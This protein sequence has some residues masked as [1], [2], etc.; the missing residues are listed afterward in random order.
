MQIG[1]NNQVA[2]D[3]T[4]NSTTITSLAAITTSHLPI[5]IADSH[6]IVTKCM[7]FTAKCDPKTAT[8]NNND[9]YHIHMIINNNSNKPDLV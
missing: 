1:P 3:A 2:Y 9:D 8:N 6:L 5:P 4:T 7:C